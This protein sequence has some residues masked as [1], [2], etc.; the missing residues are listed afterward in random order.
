[1]NPGRELDVLV[2]E[3][4]FGAKVLHK[5]EKYGWR[6]DYVATS[7]S[8]PANEC[9][10]PI[11]SDAGVECYRLKHFSTDIKAAWGVVDKLGDI[12]SHVVRNSNGWTAAIF[13]KGYLFGAAGKFPA[14]A[15]CMVAVKWLEDK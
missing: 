11:L 8:S 7:E 5:N 6:V 15:I 3:R 10:D 1:M 4:V 12:F 9:N 2:A 13:D 14:H